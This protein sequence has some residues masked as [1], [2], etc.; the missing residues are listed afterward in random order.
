MII[1]NDLITGKEIIS[2]SFDLTDFPDIPGWKFVKAKKVTKDDGSGV[3]V[4]CGNAF[5]GGGEEE[6]AEGAVEKVIDIVEYFKYMGPNVL[7]KS[8][9]KTMF[10]AWIKAIMKKEKLKKKATEGG[11][12]SDAEKYFKEYQSE[13]KAFLT[14]VKKNHDDMEFFYNQSGDIDG[15]FGIA[16]WSGDCVDA[17]LFLYWPKALQEEKC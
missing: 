10:G 7:S 14:F 12:G 16:Y 1:F 2:D 15:H 11:A 9:C 3:D 13:A 5:G 17:P 6:E 4:G 8:D